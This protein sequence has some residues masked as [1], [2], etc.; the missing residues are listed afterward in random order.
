MSRLL[1]KFVNIIFM[2]LSTSVL[3]NNGIRAQTLFSSEI[4]TEIAEKLGV[5]PIVNYEPALKSE[6]RAPDRW[7]V[8][9]N[10][11]ADDKNIQSSIMNNYRNNG[12]E[13]LQWANLWNYR[14][15]EE[16]RNFTDSHNLPLSSSYFPLLLTKDL[17][18]SCKESVKILNNFIDLENDSNLLIEKL[19][20]AYEGD[21]FMVWLH[22]LR[23]LI[24]LL[25]NFKLDDLQG[26]WD[27]V[28]KNTEMKDGDK[29]HKI[30]KG[31]T[32]YSISKLYDVSVESL[33][34]INELGISTIISEGSNLKIPN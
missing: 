9:L 23:I 2:L 25:E 34:K 10:I 15:R 3:F 14:C 20:Y 33:Q 29:I 26:V 13:K 27:E 12:F 30:L 32:L 22:E 1:I 21:N 18:C 24:R 6:L 31:E 17:N 11:V 28:S 5:F 16:W 8:I 4:P 7:E 19:E